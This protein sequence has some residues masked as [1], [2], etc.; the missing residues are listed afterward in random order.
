[1]VFGGLAVKYY[2]ANREVDDLDLL[3]SPTMKN[4]INIYQAFAKMDSQGLMEVDLCKLDYRR[5]SEFG[6]Q[7]RLKN[8]LN[9]DILTPLPDFDF[10]ISYINSVE[11]KINY[12]PV[13]IISCRDLLSYK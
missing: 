13:R 10:C 5:L 4:A 9:A 11:V 1:M 3:V 8:F 2:C 6:V 7:I 12:V